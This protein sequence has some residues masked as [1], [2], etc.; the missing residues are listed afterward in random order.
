MGGGRG[1]GPTH[2]QSLEKHFMGVPGLDVIALNIFVDSGEL[3]TQSISSGNPVL[4]IENK[5]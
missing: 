5:S 4:F 1:Y 2:S 3:L